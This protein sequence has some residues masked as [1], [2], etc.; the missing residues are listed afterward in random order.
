MRVIYLHPAVMEH[1]VGEHPGNRNHQDFP[2]SIA[3]HMGGVLRYIWEAYCDTNGRP[4][5]IQMGGV[6]R[7]LPLSRDQWHRKHCN[8]NWRRI[9]IQMGGVLQYFS[10]R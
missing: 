10:E 8:T 3:I 9:A 7:Y 2:Q 1:L 6:L 4:I 5:A